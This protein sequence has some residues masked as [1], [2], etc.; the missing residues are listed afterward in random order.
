MVFES[1]V[2]L[3]RKAAALLA[4][5]KTQMLAQIN[6]LCHMRHVLP[7]DQAGAN[8]GQLA[9]APL[10]MESEECLCH[11]ESQ[12]SVAKILKPLIVG[13]QRT[14]LPVSACAS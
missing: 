11:D 6:F 8:A 14:F 10:R 3:R 13:R 12:N 4:A 5:A 7:A 9:F 1:T 2:L